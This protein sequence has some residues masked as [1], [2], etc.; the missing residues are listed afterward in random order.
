MTITLKFLSGR[1]LT[2]RWPDGDH[3]GGW[4]GFIFSTAQPEEQPI[5]SWIYLRSYLVEKSETENKK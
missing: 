2:F 4:G 3:G 5:G 1:K